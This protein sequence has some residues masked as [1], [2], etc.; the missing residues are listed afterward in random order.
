MAWSG[1]GITAVQPDGTWSEFNNMPSASRTAILEKFAQSISPFS[2]IRIVGQYG[3]SSSRT[4]ARTWIQAM[5]N[6]RSDIYIHYGLANGSAVYLPTFYT[7]FISEML[8]EV[9][10]ARDN[11]VNEFQVGNEFEIT[12]QR[13]SLSITSIN[14]VSNVSTVVTSSAH[15]LTSGDTVNI[16]G[17]S[18]S[19]FNGNDQ[20]VTVVDTTTFTYSNSGTDGSAG[21]TPVLRAGDATLIRFIK[22][23]AV[24]GRAVA[25]SLKF[26]Y[27]VSQGY[28]TYW[29]S[30]TPGVDL[31]TIGL[32]VYGDTGYD[33]FVSI[34]STMWAIFG[35]QMIISEFNTHSS[36]AA[37]RIRG[38]SPS[39]RGFD[40]AYGDEIAR[41]R[42]Y[43]RTLGLEQ[44][45]FFQSWNAAA[46]SSN[47]NNFTVYYN[48]NPT[49]GSRLYGNWKSGYDR[50]LERRVS[51]VFLGT[52]QGT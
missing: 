31:D 36:W 34:V 51:K 5:R 22:L 7:S 20:V 15:G 2:R 35:T 40:I 9:V 27:S 3:F 33:N 32:D 52:Q 18:P 16:T 17:S 41:R 49:T 13:G 26:T 23:I 28:Q 8:P 25:P 43:L 12:A 47:N 30:I 24:A 50:L 10:W 21:G 38:M 42:D 44:A 4:A 19:S 45:Y 46:G 11:G 1:L 14:R 37:V 48:T 6:E 29:T 39:Q